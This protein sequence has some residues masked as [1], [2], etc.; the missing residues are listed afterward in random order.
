[1]IPLQ[2][3]YIGKILGSHI[4]ISPILLVE[5]ISLKTFKTIGSKPPMKKLCI[6][7][8]FWHEISSLKKKDMKYV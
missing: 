5:S 3:L 8:K 6:I 1:M 7:V 2:T 4:K